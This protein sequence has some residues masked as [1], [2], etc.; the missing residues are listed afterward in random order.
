[1]TTVAINVPCQEWRSW[2]HVAFILQI[3]R[4]WNSESYLLYTPVVNWCQC[5]IS[6]EVCS[7]VCDESDVQRHHRL[8]K[9]GKTV[10]M[11]PPVWTKFSQKHKQQVA[12]FL[13]LNFSWRPCPDRPCSSHSSVE[14]VLQVQSVCSKWWDEW[15]CGQQ[16]G[17][18]SP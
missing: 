9:K 15:D 7:A 8:L 4:S 10:E 13:P 14:D 16:K 18:M 2:Q 6:H 3:P 17:H 11:T 12:L 1:M 5:F